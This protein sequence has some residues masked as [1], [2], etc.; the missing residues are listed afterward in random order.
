M[1]K[2]ITTTTNNLEGWAITSYFQPVSSNI[3]VGANIFSDFSASITDFF[4]GRSG[5]Y[6]KKL[7]QIYEQAILNLQKKAKALNANAIVGLKIDIDEITGKGT[8]MF[9]ITAYGTPVRAVRLNSEVVSDDVNVHKSIDGAY[10]ENKVLAKRIIE[11]SEKHKRLDLNDLNFILEH[12]Y[13]EFV[14]TMI[15]YARRNSTRFTSPEDDTVA[16]QLR[17]FFSTIDNQITSEILYR[18]LRNSNFGD[19]YPL[20]IR[21]TIKELNIIDYNQLRDLINTRDLQLGKHALNIL[22][23]QR[24]SYS[25]NDQVELRD[26]KKLIDDIFKPVSTLYP[27]DKAQV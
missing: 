13:P 27:R 18:E 9:M 5:T 6:E 16:M 26:L 4:G 15:T 17:T 23:R 12:P 22:S 10:V 3:V 24:E 19:K 20:I 21:D 2:L 7:Q 14:D 11:R 8:Q 25:S 1:S